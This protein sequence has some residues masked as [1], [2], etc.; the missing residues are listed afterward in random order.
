MKIEV[1]VKHMK[2]SGMLKEQNK[3]EEEAREFMH[4]FFPKLKRWECTCT[5]WSCED[6]LSD[7]SSYQNQDGGF[8]YNIEANNWNPNSS[9]YTV[10]IALDYLDTAGDYEGNLKHNMVQGIIKY[11]ASGAYLTEN[12]W[13]GMQGIPTN[14]DFAHMPW[15]HHDPQK[16]T[17]ADVGLTKRLSDFI[18]EYAGKSSDIYQKA[19][20]LKAKYKLCG[21]TLLNG[22]PD[23]DLTSFEPTSFDPAT[24]PFWKPLPVYFVGSPQSEHY[25]AL[26]N[27]ENINLD[28]IVDSLC[29][30]NELHIIPEKEINAFEKNN[31]PPD[32]KGWG[33]IEQIIG[34]YYW[35]A[36]GITSDMDILRKFDRL[37]FQ[38]PIHS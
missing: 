24:W 11:L 1:S 16:P 4:S 13:V 8:G 37:D 35:G 25:P 21:Q 18:L 33:R 28:T 17:E 26:K 2:E 3:T 27:V 12:G 14:N 36:H 38:L 5:E 9:P 29:N 23:Y 20:V 19:A 6:F 15:F 30:T 7:L 31:P 34:N 10:C 32:G 22:I